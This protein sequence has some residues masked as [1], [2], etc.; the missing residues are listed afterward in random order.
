MVGGFHLVRPRTEDEARKTVAELALIDPAYIVPMH[1]TG[2]VFIQEAL[3]VMPEK[4]VRPYV[5]TELIFSA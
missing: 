5:G 3:R 2:E 4:I 1:C